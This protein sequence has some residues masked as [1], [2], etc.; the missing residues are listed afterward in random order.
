MSWFE[1]FT[2]ADG[3]VMSHGFLNTAFRDNLLEQE[4]AKA[5]AA[6]DMFYATAPNSLAR[7][8]IGSQGQALIVSE[9]GIPEWGDGEWTWT[10]KS[11]DQQCSHPATNYPGDLDGDS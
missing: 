5:L 6:G 1:P 11:Q 10:V 7:L 8:A 2:L 9:D 4:P 3:R